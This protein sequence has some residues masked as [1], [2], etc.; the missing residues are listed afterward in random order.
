[1]LRVRV[2]ETRRRL[3]NVTN[4]RASHVKAI[5]FE[6][7]MHL[8]NVILPARLHIDI[9][10]MEARGV[11]HEFNAHARPPD[12]IRQVYKRYQTLPTDATLLQASL[13]QSPP[14]TDG[15]YK[16]QIDVDEDGPTHSSDVD[17]IPG[18]MCMS[19]CPQHYS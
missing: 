18:K 9:V 8:L 19:T 16:P 11:E 2:G 6:P 14:S 7:H 15:Q 1:M 10:E 5:S 13:I 12:A 4:L 3:G 17:G